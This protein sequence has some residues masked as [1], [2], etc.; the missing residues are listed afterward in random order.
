VHNSDY[1][2]ECMLRYDLGPPPGGWLHMMRLYQQLGTVRLWKVKGHKLVSPYQRTGSVGNLLK[3]SNF[4]LQKSATAFFSLY[5]TFIISRAHVYNNI[6]SCGHNS[7]Y[8]NGE[9][10]I[11]IYPRKYCQYIDSHAGF[12]YSHIPSV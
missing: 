4:I 8:N 1:Y 9:I 7:V 11:Q 6:Y 10:S 2:S 12:V 5:L 3:I